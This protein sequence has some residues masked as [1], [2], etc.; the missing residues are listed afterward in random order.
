MSNISHL[1]YNM[2][3]LLIVC[4]CCFDNVLQRVRKLNHCHSALFS[5]TGALDTDK[6]SPASTVLGESA[7]FDPGLPSHLHLSINN[8]SPVA[9]WS[10]SFQVVSIWEWHCKAVPVHAENMAKSSPSSLLHLVYDVVDVGASP[11]LRCC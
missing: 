3:V 6:S 10:V 5:P 7:K 4:S 2:W 11:R 1:G 8:P 9:Q